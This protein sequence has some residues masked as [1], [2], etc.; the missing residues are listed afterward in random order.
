MTRLLPLA[1]SYGGKL[2]RHRAD[3]KCGRPLQKQSRADAAAGAA[4]LMQDQPS[5]C[6]SASS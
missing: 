5:F 3:C 4:C 1:D 2:P 6:F